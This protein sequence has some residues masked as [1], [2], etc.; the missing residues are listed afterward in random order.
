V[1]LTA[2]TQADP[3]TAGAR[4]D[5]ASCVGT[6]LDGELPGS[7]RGG[8]CVPNTNCVDACS[9]AYAQALAVSYNQS[10][11]SVETC[12]GDS[13]CL[14]TRA[15]TI[16]EFQSHALNELNYCLNLCWKRREPGKCYQDT[17]C[18][19][20]GPCQP[21]LCERGACTVYSMVVGEA[22]RRGDLQGICFANEC[23]TGDQYLLGCGKTLAR[24]GVEHRQH[25]EDL[26]KCRA[27]GQCISLRRRVEGY[28]KSNG[29]LFLECVEAAIDAGITK[30]APGGAQR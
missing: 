22:C 19:S 10:P 5:G 21:G 2:S 26:A 30:G 18:P 7:M 14:E 25:E 15:A 6:G 16:T 28:I 17:D 11:Q 23:V 9:T 13:E 4:A 1:L 24:L 27:T 20:G 3:G 8:V 12:A 29:V